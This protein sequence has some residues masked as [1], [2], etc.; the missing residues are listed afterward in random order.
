[1]S[2]TS[3]YNTYLQRTAATKPIGTDIPL[4]G[5]GPLIPPYKNPADFTPDPTQIPGYTPP[6]TGTGPILPGSS[7]G[8]GTATGG[9]TPSV[10]QRAPAPAPMMDS[11]DF[12]PPTQGTVLQRAPAPVAQEEYKPSEPVMIRPNATPVEGSTFEK[13]PLGPTQFSSTP[14]QVG[15][16]AGAVNTNL[17]DYQATPMTEQGKLFGDAITRDLTS[18]DNPYVRSVRETA[19]RKATN[20]SYQATKQAEESLGA[21]GVMPGTSQYLRAMSRGQATAN[22]ANR[23]LFNQSAGVQRDFYQKALDRGQDFEKTTYDRANTERTTAI[24]R[25][26]YGDDRSDK[27]NSVNETSRLENKGDTLAAINSIQDPTARQA[28]MNAYL[29]GGNVREFIGGMYEDGGQLK[30]T[31]QGETPG[32]LKNRAL[33]DQVR[34][35]FTGRTNPSTGQPYSEQEIQDYISRYSV[36]SLE[37]QYNPVFQGADDRTTIE[38]EGRLAKGGRPTPEDLGRMNV[39]PYT[40]I[41]YSASE[42]KNFNSTSKTGGWVKLP[43]G[44][45]YKVVGQKSPV[46]NPNVIFN[47]NHTDYVKLEDQDG[48]IVWMDRSGKM[49]K[50]EPSNEQ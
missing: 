14:Y 28:A 17:K 40:A 2:I 13:A 33:E 31:Y 10:L 1:M 7:S 26:K 34:Q 46:S 9:I 12:T 20:N 35:A 16:Q 49:T 50:I 41:P 32:A 30:K 37:N 3:P 39:T 45:A 8:T 48:N 4:G 11:Q 47:D 15:N 36:S 43:D 44:K 38:M 21:Q 5:S 27:Q 25:A 19:E 42:L 24:E 6:K 18:A 29:K 22:D 23:D